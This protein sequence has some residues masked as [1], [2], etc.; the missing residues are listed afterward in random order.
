MLP[1]VRAGLKVLAA[2]NRGELQEAFAAVD[3]IRTGRPKEV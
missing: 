1:L 3:K 2:M